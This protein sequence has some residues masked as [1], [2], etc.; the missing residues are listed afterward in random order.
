MRNFLLTTCL[1]VTAVFAAGAANAN[2][3][4]QK[5]SQN[6]KDWVMPAGTYDNQRFSQLKQIT[7][8]NVGKRR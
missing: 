4:L 3:E 8:D 6:P 5:M 7:A 1:G 2:D